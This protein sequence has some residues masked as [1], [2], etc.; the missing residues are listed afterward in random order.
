MA[1]VTVTVTATVIVTVTV[2]AT[3]TA[4]VIVTITVNVTFIIP[5]STLVPRF[6]RQT[7]PRQE[8]RVTSSGVFKEFCFTL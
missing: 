4:T 1:V 6:F 8:L 3:A 5:K 2:T 7:Q